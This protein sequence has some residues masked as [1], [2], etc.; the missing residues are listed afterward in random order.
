MLRAYNYILISI[1]HNLAYCPSWCFCGVKTKR[2]VNPININTCP[3]GVLETRK[4]TFCCWNF[5]FS[6]FGKSRWNDVILCTTFFYWRDKLSS[7]WKYAIAPLPNGAL[8]ELPPNYVKRC[9]AM[10]VNT[11]TLCIVKDETGK[12]ATPIPTY[13]G[14]KKEFRST[15]NVEYWIWFFPCSIK[16]CVIGSKKKYVLGWPIVPNMQLMKISTNLLRE[17]VLALEDA[18]FQLQ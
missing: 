9:W 2:C 15:N 8:Q 4:M 16:R 7:G 3:N 18:E 11:K 1:I 13:K 14:M 12:H 5:I 17:E 6:P 10:Q